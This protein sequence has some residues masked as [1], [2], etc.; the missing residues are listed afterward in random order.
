MPSDIAALEG[1]ADGRAAVTRDDDIKIVVVRIPGSALT[2]E[3][4]IRYLIP[5][6][7]RFTVPR[8]IEF[9]PE[10][11]RTP[12]GKVRKVELRAA[13]RGGWDRVAVGIDVPR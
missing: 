12:T 8:Y 10:L 7:P 9:A 1:D 11:P 13:H 3:D 4:L 2:D 6:L 5:R